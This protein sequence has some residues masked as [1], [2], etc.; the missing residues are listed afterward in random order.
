MEIVQGRMRAMNS[1]TELCHRGKEVP[2]DNDS[3]GRRIREEINFKYEDQTD[4]NR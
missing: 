4:T 1:V 3:I 2:G